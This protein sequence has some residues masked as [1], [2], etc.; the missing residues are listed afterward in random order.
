MKLPKVNFYWGIK[1]IAGGKWK[2]GLFS[3][4]DARA[5]SASRLRDWRLV[6]SLRGMLLWLVALA[7]AAYFAGAGGLWWWLHRRPYN[8]VTYA[9]LVLPSR[10]PELQH[11]RG[12][13]QIKAGLADF[14]NYKWR[15]GEMKLRVGLSRSPADASARLELA[16]FYVAINQRSQAKA[17]LNDGLNHGF[18]GMPYIKNICALA[19]EGENYD[20]SIQVCDKALAQMAA[21]RERTAERRDVTLQKMA[22]LMAANRPDDVLKIVDTQGDKAGPMFD[23]FRVLALIKAGRAAAAVASLE[24]WRKRSG[25]TPQV[26]RLQVRAFREVGRL[27][28]MEQ[29]VEE[30]RV[31]TPASPQPY[32]YGI[33]QYLLAGRWLKAYVCVDDFLLRFGSNPG[34]LLALAEPLVEIDDRVVLEQLIDHAR[35]HGFNTEPL[36]GALLKVLVDKGEWLQARVLLS[37]IRSQSKADTRERIFWYEL[38]DRLSNAAL[39][40]GEGTQSSLID[41]V[42]GKKLPFKIH[43]LI[44]THLRAAGRPA[45]A[46]ALISF[47]EGDYPET[48]ALKTW[49]DELDKELAVLAAASPKEVVSPAVTVADASAVELPAAR[50]VPPADVFFSRLADAVKANDFEGALKQILATRNARPEWLVKR[51]ADIEIEEIRI[52]GRVGDLPAQHVAT[53]FY[54][55][56]DAKR[57]LKAAELARELY[58]AGCKEPAILLARDLLRKTPDYPPAKRMLAEWEP[59]PVSSKP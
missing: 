50:E 33:I 9:D 18:P 31:C 54:L 58:A 21:D 42:R 2:L 52:N 30:L 45:T 48:A 57:S 41:F 19:A 26:M 10:W 17:L 3:F 8:E 12:Q 4:Y 6:L 27:A 29:A 49:R 23:E 46:R 13:A 36:Q 11:K 39:D 22:V 35:Q 34:N 7:F 51:E 40:P 28:N 56:G 38:V 44:I 5:T 15:E 20:W 53:R 25:A 47:V 37:E 59:K 32:I 55:N 1:P 16:R 24:A 14:K 43:R